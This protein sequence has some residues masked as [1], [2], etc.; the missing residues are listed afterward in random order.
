MKCYTTSWDTIQ[1][2]YDLWHAKQHS[3]RLK[4]RRFPTL[5]VA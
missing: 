1:M 4:V 2:N 3:D 5:E